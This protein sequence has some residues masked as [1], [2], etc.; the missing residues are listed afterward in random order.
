MNKLEIIK[1]LSTVSSWNYV[2]RLLILTARKFA[3]N[4]KV[5][6]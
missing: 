1:F 6:Q 5:S 4:Y 3:Q 2:E